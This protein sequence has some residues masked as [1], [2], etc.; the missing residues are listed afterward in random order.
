MSTSSLP[1]NVQLQR[2]LIAILCFSAYIPA[3]DPLASFHSRFPVMAT[4]GV[5]AP[6]DPSY[7]FVTSPFLSPGALAAVRALLGLYTL[8]TL[9]TVF[10][11]NVAR[12][13]AESFF[14]Y[15]TELSFIGLTAYYLTAAV[16]TV[17]YAHSR[18]YPLRRWPRIFQFLHVL[19]QT[20]IT[21]FPFLVTIVFWVLLASPDVFQTRY[22]T[23]SNISIHALNSLFALI[24]ILLT[25][26]PPAPWLALPVHIVMLGGYLGVAYITHATQGFYTYGFLDPAK[27]KAL[28]AGYIVGIAV[29]QV[30]VFLLVRGVVV[31]RERVA[32][33]MGSVPEKE[34]VVEKE[35]SSV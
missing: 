13:T 3:N 32:G 9:G 15:F 16:H 23:W 22:S 20:T 14:S 18:T 21:T 25:S 6:F 30:V 27:G 1:L 2:C 12:G 4:F 29:G 35:S 17:A 31:L 11:F 33:K 5:A 8:A 10:G 7:K 28:L 19:L 34:L 26:T 24:E